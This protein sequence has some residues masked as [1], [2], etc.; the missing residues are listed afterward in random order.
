LNVPFKL[1]TFLDDVLL[2]ALGEM[3][4]G[5][6]VLESSSLVYA[7]DAFCK[8][9]RFSEEEL[10]LL[11]SFFD[12]LDDADSEKTLKKIISLPKNRKTPERHEVVIRGKQKDKIYLELTAHL[13]QEDAHSHLIL[14]IRDLTEKNRLKEVVRDQESQ[15][16]LL[17]Q[18]NP[19]PLFIYDLDSLGILTVN[20]AAVEKYG[21]AESEF[22]K[23]TMKELRP[24]EDV[25]KLLKKVDDFKKDRKST[26]LNSSHRL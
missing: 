21:Y 10:L 7:N 2:T 23:M 16:K 15:Y 13:I 19:N 12:L 4:D 1:K 14:L 22:L 9:T 25:P 24:P 3:G 20:R 8:F 6:V 5:I 17:F 18:N 26:R 11:P